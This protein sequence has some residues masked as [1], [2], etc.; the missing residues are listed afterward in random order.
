MSTQEAT[1]SAPAVA[2]AA[3]EKA[4]KKRYSKNLKDLQK[5][6]DRATKAAFKIVNAVAVGIDRYRSES[7][8]S[9]RKKKDGAI[10]DRLPNLA[11]AVGK[12]VR[13]G[14]K[15]SG[16]IGKIWDS[17]KRRKRTKRILKSLR[18]FRIWR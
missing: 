18:Q 7:D 9:A 5:G 6:R 16:D 10:R 2:E 13:V 12:A 1:S 14:S 8:K 4:K 17:K 11:E 3:P 15:A